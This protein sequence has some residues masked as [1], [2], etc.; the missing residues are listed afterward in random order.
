MSN[1]KEYFSSQEIKKFDEHKRFTAERY[2]KVTDYN[3]TAKELPQKGKEF[4]DQAQAEST[5]KQ[6]S[7]IG[8]KLRKNMTQT[9]AKAATTSVATTVAAAVGGVVVLSTMFAPTPTIDLQ[10][11]D[12]GHNVVSYTIT[13][14][15]FQEDIYYFV[16]IAN[17]YDI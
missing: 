13:A 10:T 5:Q 17:P 2:L 6:K 16:E 1:V 12:A 14:E 3:P 7:T 11:L 8:Q 9:T 15:D 4:F